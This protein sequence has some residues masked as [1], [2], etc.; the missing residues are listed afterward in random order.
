MLKHIRQIGTFTA[1]NSAGGSI[2]LAVFEVDTDAGD[3]QDPNAEVEALKEIRTF[4]GR[5]VNWISKGKYHIVES[6]EDLT[7][8]D[9]NAP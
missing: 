4:D 1:R 5:H 7:S 6:D 2:R 3:L 9:L 8:D